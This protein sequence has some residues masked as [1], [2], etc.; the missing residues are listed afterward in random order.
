MD[1]KKEMTSLNEPL[2]NIDIEE[3]SVEALERRFELAVAML[4]IDDCVVQCNSDVC[5][6]ICGPICRPIVA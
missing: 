3:V 1:R 2:W 5:Q 4:Y 6:D